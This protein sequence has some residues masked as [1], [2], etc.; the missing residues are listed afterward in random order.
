MTIIFTWQTKTTYIHLFW[1]TP[2]LPPWFLS[3][4]CIWETV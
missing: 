1:G 3:I 2:G 4:Q